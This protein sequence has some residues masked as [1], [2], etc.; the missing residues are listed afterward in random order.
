CGVR[1]A[2]ELKMD[3]IPI[4]RQLVNDSSAAVRRDCAIALRHS[5][6]PDAADLWADLAMKHDGQDR[7]YLEALGIGADGNEDAFFDA[8]FYKMKEN[9]NTPAG[10][11]IVGRGRIGRWD[12]W[13]KLSRSRISV[14][15][16][17]RDI[18]GP[19]IFTVERARR[20]RWAGCW[21]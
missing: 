6:S 18:S 4:V 17:G 8:W 3:V 21:M 10:R 9:W 14:A 16:S 11:D 20:R 15:R 12:Y 2:R 13:R 19:W 7:W 5:K 1:I